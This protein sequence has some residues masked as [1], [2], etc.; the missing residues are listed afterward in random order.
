VIL[1]IDNLDGNGAIDY[2]AALCADAPLSIERVLN[3]PSRCSGAL[4]VGSPANPGASSALLVPVRRGR[5]V[6]NSLSGAV[7]FTGYLATDPVP[8]FVGAGL[9][10]PVYRVAFSAISDEWL[11]DKQSLTLTA[12]GFTVP[13]GSLLQTLTARTAAGLF[14]TTEVQSGQPIGVFTPQPAQPWST[15]AGNIAGSTYAAYRV[16]NGS[17]SMNPV[18]SV[19]HSLDFDA[20]LGDGT[21]QVAALNTSM[22]K[23]L[24]NDVTLSGQIEPTAYV[25]ELFA[26]D[27]ITTLFTLSDDPFRIAKPTLLTE[28]FNQPAFNT[29]IWNVSDPGSHLALGPTGLSIAGGNGFDGQTTLVAIDQVEL[30]GSLVLEAGNVLLTSPSDGVLC[31]LYSGPIQRANCFAGYNVRQSAGATVLTPFV[32]GAEVGTTYT[33]LSGR[34]Y[35]LRIR[36][37]SPE[38][39]RVLQTYYARVD[40]AIQAF[41]GGLVI[42]PMQLVFE[43]VDMGNAS[44]TPA[45]VLYDS[46]VAGA[47][48]SSPASCSFAPVDSVELTGSMGFCTV[49]QTGSAWIVSTLPGGTT[50][51]RLIGVAGEGVD[52]SLT[53]TGKLTFFSGRIPVAGE[54]VTVSYRLRSRAIAR[55]ED[56]ASIAAEAAGGM[57]GTA[58]WL[59][60]VLRPFARCSADCESAAQATLSF[61]SSR[62][63]AIAGSY[64][65]INPNA[66]VWPG[67]VLS[68]VANGQTINVVVRRVSIID[69]NSV[70][71]LLTY[72]IAFA[73]DWAES[74][75]VTISEAIAPDSFLPPIAETTSGAVLANLQQLTVTSAT[76]TALQID[77]GTAPPTGGGFEVRLRDWNF[78][79]GVD[80]NLVLRSPVRSFSIPRTA[81]QERYYVRMFDASNSPLY[82]RLSSAFFTNLP[83]A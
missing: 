1:T 40:G 22:V 78:G 2:S 15:N 25:S 18:G 26:G 37:H 16:L 45:T 14:S 54:I 36:L 13:A 68:I 64:A 47:I 63:A 29:Q 69:G 66:D 57:P 56:A 67:D 70:P 3:T 80:Q 35:N 52:C 24:A 81:Q 48:A 19:T 46:A 31:G 72:R 38:M 39:Q 82:S 27:G 50:Q 32:N 55:L 73:N 7:L 8:V 30:G 41:G 9:A 75:G 77:A 28:S 4:Q 59:G 62:A 23:E 51:T 71:D 6:V 65:A 44:N 53:S 21:L 60:K 61:A 12:D 58:R 43:L 49:T 33:L 5:V 17:L 83:V 11:L 34:T 20:G 42:S 74:L 10:G 76:T 79:P